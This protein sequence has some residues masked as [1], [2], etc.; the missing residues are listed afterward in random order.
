M[1]SPLFTDRARQMADVEEKHGYMKNGS[2]P[3]AFGKCKVVRNTILNTDIRLHS[4]F[5]GV[6]GDYKQEEV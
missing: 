6:H 3:N 5:G 1:I 2:L 4:K